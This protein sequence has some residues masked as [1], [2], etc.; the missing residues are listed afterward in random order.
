MQPLVRRIIEINPKLPFGLCTQKMAQVKL[1][2]KIPI[3]LQQKTKFQAEKSIFRQK[4]RYLSGKTKFYKKPQEKMLLLSEIKRI[5]QAPLVRDHTNLVK[6]SFSKREPEKWS[7]REKVDQR[8]GVDP[9]KRA[10]IRV[11]SVNRGEREERS[12]LRGGEWQRERARDVF[13]DRFG[14]SLSI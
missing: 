2:S 13:G 3:E 14:R 7:I 10:P 11:M 1:D 8:E 12:I 4:I 6:E 5:Q 9:R